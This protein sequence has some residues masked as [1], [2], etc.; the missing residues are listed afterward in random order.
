ML[1]R[2]ARQPSAKQLA[3]EYTLRGDEGTLSFLRAAV[4]TSH[5]SAFISMVTLL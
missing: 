1:F 2:L 3:T 4:M 5:G